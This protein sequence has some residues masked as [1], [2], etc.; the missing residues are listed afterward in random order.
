VS[1]PT[2]LDDELARLWR[3]ADR[4]FADGSQQVEFVGHF[5]AK[6]RDATDAPEANTWRHGARVAT[7]RARAEFK[8]HD[9]ILDA[10]ARLQS[11]LAPE[12]P[13]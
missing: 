3:Q 10:I 2:S 9:L 8:R 4:H 12:G 1:A 5:R 6:L 13:A 11:P 7:A